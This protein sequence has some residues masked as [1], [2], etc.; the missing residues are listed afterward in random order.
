MKVDPQSCEQWLRDHKVPYV[1]IDGNEHRDALK[2]LKPFFA[3]L[4]MDSREWPID[5][6]LAAL[7]D[8]PDDAA[9]RQWEKSFNGGPGRFRAGRIRMDDGNVKVVLLDGTDVTKEITHG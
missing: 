9:M 4:Y 6:V 8:E 3:V 7:G 1:I 5:A 2:G